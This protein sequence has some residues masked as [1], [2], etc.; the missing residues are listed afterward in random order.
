MPGGSGNGTAEMQKTNLKQVQLTN[1]S[2]E[3]VKSATD[4]N[5]AVARAFAAND[6][7][8]V[9]AFLKAMGVTVADNPSKDQVE[10][11]LR[12]L[13]AKTIADPALRQKYFMDGKR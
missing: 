9:I 10:V 12:A 2:T 11:A 6:L 5:Q 3:E 8:K 1:V 7:S 4:V 13:G